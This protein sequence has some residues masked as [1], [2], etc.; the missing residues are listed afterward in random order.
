MNSNRFNK[1]FESKSSLGRKDITAYGKT[2]D[3]KIKH[4]IEANASDP[5]ESDALEGWEQLSYD[6]SNMRSLDKTFAPNNILKY[7]IVSS[8]I[9]GLSIVGIALFIQA[10][11]ETKD[12]KDVLENTKILTSEKAEKQ[13]FSE[14]TSDVNIPERIEQMNLAPKEKQIEVL[15]IQNNF[16]AQKTIKVPQK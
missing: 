7:Y 15:T 12:N 3:E 8:V 16:Q 9:V 2:N 1:I 14:T 4:S 11:Q 13:E 10:T 5:F 6:I